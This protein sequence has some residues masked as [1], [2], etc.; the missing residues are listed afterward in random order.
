MQFID[1]ANLWQFPEQNPQIYISKAE[2]EIVLKSEA[3]YTLS[4][5]NKKLWLPVD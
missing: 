3:I 4:R 5:L 2:Q 1:I